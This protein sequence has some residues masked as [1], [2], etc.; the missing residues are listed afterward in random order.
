MGLNTLNQLIEPLLAQHLTDGSLKLSEKIFLS[1]VI[2][3]RED[4]IGNFLYVGG[5]KNPRGEA[6][7]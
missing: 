1:G 4:I 3:N 6:I 2:P 7:T 5:T